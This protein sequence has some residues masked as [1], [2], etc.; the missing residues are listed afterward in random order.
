VKSI[1]RTTTKSDVILNG[2]TRFS[3]VPAGTPIK[4]LASIDTA[5]LPA[6]TQ[7]SWFTGFLN[8]LLGR[9]T[10]NEIL[11]QRS[12][13]PDFIEDRGHEFGSHLTNDE[14]R[15]LIEYVKTF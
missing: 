2:Q 13:A 5:N 8:K 6:I 14:K 4:L 12:T 7:Q 15:A 10:Y 11:L 3:G 1:L 9:Q